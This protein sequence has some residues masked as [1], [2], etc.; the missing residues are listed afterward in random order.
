M[1]ILAIDTSAKTATAALCEDEKL[2]S[3]YSSY[4][5]Y[6][7]SQTLLPMIKSLFDNAGIS[8]SDVELFAVS[9]GPGSF[10][11]VR[12]GVSTVKGLAFGKNVAAIGVSTLL[13]LAENVKEIALDAVI[14]P[15]M[16]A[17]RGEV[18]NALFEVK[19]GN[20]VRLCEDR[21]I[22]FLSLLDEL[23]AKN[24]PVY[25][26]GDGYFM[27]EQVDIPF[28]KETPYILREQN[29]YSVAKC[30]YYAYSSADDK[31]IFTDKDLSV[32][33]LRMSQAEREK[34]KER[35]N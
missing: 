8:A 21:A 6:T 33:Y 19:D 2:I 28:Q 26:C 34:K 29:A 32:T 35:Q 22:S 18:Y 16:D 24:R 4:T 13:A 5:G 12:I 1:K 10:T 15:I 3:V 9:N 25:F 23:N 14:C 11:G 30:A 27:T 20:L 17:R 31:S 7:H